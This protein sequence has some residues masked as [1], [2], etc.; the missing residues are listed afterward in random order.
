M[1]KLLFTQYDY[2]KWRPNG[3]MRNIN[4]SEVRTKYIVKQENKQEIGQTGKIWT[5]SCDTTSTGI[6]KQQTR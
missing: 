2:M 1:M 4:N 6:R 3:N 5:Y